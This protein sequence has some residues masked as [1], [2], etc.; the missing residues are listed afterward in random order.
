MECQKQLFSLP[1]DEIYLNCARKAPQS[2]RI[3]EIALAAIRK[4]ANP[5]AITGKDFFGPVTELKRE[6]SKLIHCTEPDRIAI[7]PS[8]SYGLATV[9]KNLELRAGDKILVVSEQFPSNIYPWMTEI[10]AAGAT[11]E[12]IEPPTTH[13]RG[14]NWNEAILESIDDQTRMIALGQVHWADGTLFDLAAIRKKTLQHNALMVIDG[15]QSVGALPFSVS[16]LQPDALIVAGYKWLL[17]PY[18]LGCAYYG[19]VFDGGRPIEENWINRKDSDDFSQLIHYQAEYRPMAGRYSVGE[20][21]NFIL[22]PLLLEAL[23]QLN[24]WGVSNIQNYCEQITTSA[25]KNWMEMGLDIEGAKHR[26]AHLFGVRLSE[27]FELKELQKQ[28]KTNK[29]SVSI[30]GNAIRVA[31]NVYNY[32]EELQALGQCFEKARRNILI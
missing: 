28:L 13:N 3:E 4:Q 27:K 8:V 17:G 15:T 14:A 24:E 1:E 26:G 2:K 21:S 31:P 6:F 32:E 18:S 25:I 23:K 29:I 19:P 30:R 16:E 5:N 20:Q 11:M 12:I 10:K 22:V 9:A 7:I